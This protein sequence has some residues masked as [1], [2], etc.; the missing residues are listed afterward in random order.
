MIQNITLDKFIFAWKDI[1]YY[2]KVFHDIWTFVG[3]VQE[4]QD[5]VKMWLDLTEMHPLL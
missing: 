3:A 4:G 5:S 1:E 2:F